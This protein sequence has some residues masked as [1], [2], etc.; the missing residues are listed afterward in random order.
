MSLYVNNRV[1]NYLVFFS[2]LFC[3]VLNN[4]NKD[5]KVSK[6]NITDFTILV[7]SRTLPKNKGYVLLYDL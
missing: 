4:W 3:I 7:H 1:Y 6:K 2:I 5:N